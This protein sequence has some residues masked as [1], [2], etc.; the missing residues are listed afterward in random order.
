LYRLQHE[1]T[2]ARRD[3]GVDDAHIRATVRLKVSTTAAT[4][5]AAAFAVILEANAN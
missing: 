3:P 4:R 1:C 2:D 5:A